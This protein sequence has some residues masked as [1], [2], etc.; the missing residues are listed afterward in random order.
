MTPFKTVWLG[1]LAAFALSARVGTPGPVG[2][3]NVPE[4]AKAVAL[5]AY[6]GNWYEFAR[7][8]APFQRGCEAVTAN[9]SL[10]DDE[11]IRVLNSCRKGSVDG[12]LD[13]S[14]GKAKI[15][16]GSQGAKLKVSFFGPFYGDYW[17]LDRGEP[18][19]EGRYSWS[20][21][22]EPSGRYLWMLTREAKPSPELAAKLEARVKDLGYDWS[23]VR[24]TRH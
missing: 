2:N 16:E 4:P 17:I 23:L 6:L 24:K 3:A 5:D 14:T 10:R 12:E 8:E 13:Q 22:G 21:V 18:D 9:Y 20:I 11:K 15:V 1:S 7:Y 19:S